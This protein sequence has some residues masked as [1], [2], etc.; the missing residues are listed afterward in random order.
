MAKALQKNLMN[1][2]AA[3]HADALDKWVSQDAKLVAAFTYGALQALKAAAGA[4]SIKLE[5]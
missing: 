2:K 1:A 5:F 4:K 3:M